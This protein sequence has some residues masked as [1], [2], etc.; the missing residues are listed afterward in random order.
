MILEWPDRKIHG[1]PECPSNWIEGDRDNG[2]YHNCRDEQQVPWDD[3]PR[4]GEASDEDREE[5][6]ERERGRHDHC[7]DPVSGVPFEI[8]P[9]RRAVLGHREKSREEVSASA[10]GAAAKQAPAEQFEG[11]IERVAHRGGV[12]AA[13]G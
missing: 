7:T 8:V 10:P 2:R 12:Y 6:N 9:A 1:D 13:L 11:A 5:P 3:R 4:H